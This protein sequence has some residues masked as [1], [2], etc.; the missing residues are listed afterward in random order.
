MTNTGTHTVKGNEMKSEKAK[1]L[2]EKYH[3]LQREYDELAESSRLEIDALDESSRAEEELNGE[4]QARIARQATAIA[5]MGTVIDNQEETIAKQTASIANL[6]AEINRLCTFDLQKSKR[7]VKL[8]AESTNLKDL[9][10]NLERHIEELI[11]YGL[12]VVDLT[13]GVKQKLT[14][15]IALRNFEVLA[16]EAKTAL[17]ALKDSNER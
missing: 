3:A 7:I 1:M 17:D 5:N 10:D 4:L 2:K 15:L 13:Q 9:A 8:E 14:T 11:R 6:N 16:D 12:V